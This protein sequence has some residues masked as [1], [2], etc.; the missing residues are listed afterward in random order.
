MNKK[1][2]TLIEVL[3]SI[4]LFFITMVSVFH[5]FSNHIQNHN[6]I[7]EK[8]K[9]LR[10]TKDFIDSFKWSTP[11]QKEGTSNIEEYVIKWKMFPIED[12]RRVLNTSGRLTYFQLSLV[13]MSLINKNSKKQLYKTSFLVNNYKK[14]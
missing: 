2:F 7:S 12:K 8:Y 10:I 4:T 14:Q 11:L 3:V 5:Y 6:K 13:K 1:G 9:I